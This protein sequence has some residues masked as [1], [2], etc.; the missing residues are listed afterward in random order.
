MTRHPR[1]MVVA[2]TLAAAFLSGAVAQWVMCGSAAHAQ[3]QAP[4]ATPAAP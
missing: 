1:G 4:V 2:G 3:Q